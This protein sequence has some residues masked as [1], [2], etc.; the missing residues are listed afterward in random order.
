MYAIQRLEDVDGAFKSLGPFG[1]TRVAGVLKSKESQMRKAIIE[2]VT[3]SWNGL[4]YVDASNNRV[5]LK[6]S[7]ERESTV[8]ITAVV[9]QLTKLDLLDDFV[10]RFSRD[11]DRVILSRRLV[12]GRDQVVTAFEVHGDDIQL[13]G[14]VNDGSVKATLEDIHTIAEY[15]STRLPPSIAIP[16]S[17]KLVPIITSRLISH[18]LLPAVPT[19]TDGVQQFQET[20]SYV[21]GLVEYLDELGWTGQN[22]LTEWVDKSAEIWLARQKENAI[23][24]VQRLFP[25]QVKIKKTVEKVETQVISKGDALHPAQDSQDNDWGADWGMKTSPSKMQT[26]HRMW[27]KK[28]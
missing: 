5:S 8:D 12:I 10:T 4:L 3:E 23:A 28:T 19:S 18:Y 15:I 13:T 7:I 11:F 21:L 22:R 25:K 1:S 9:E 14:R 6:D 26:L 24:Q 27:K 17:S 20:L 2:T 16:L